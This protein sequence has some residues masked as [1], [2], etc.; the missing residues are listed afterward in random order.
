[1][2]RSCFQERVLKVDADSVCIG[3]E[4]VSFKVDADAVCIGTECV[5]FKVDADSVCLGAVSRRM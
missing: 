4:C 5:S 3:T 2:C 1:M